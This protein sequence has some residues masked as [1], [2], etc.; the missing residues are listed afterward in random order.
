MHRRQVLAIHNLTLHM[1]PQL[2][3]TH[4]LPVPDIPRKILPMELLLLQ[5]TASLVLHP[6]ELQEA[7]HSNNK[8]MRLPLL[9]E[10]TP[11]DIPQA[12][13]EATKLAY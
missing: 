11:L 3:R 1:V 4:L 2:Q 5:H 10:A 9:L 7:T 8:I 12:T 13:L 6:L